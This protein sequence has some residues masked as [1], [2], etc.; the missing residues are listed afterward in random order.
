[1]FPINDL[2]AGPHAILPTG[3]A[4]Q[5]TGEEAHL[6]VLRSMLNGAEERSAWA[7]LHAAQPAKPTAKPFVEV[8]ILDELVGRLTPATSAEFLP[9]I[10]HLGARV[11]VAR[12]AIRGSALKVDVTIRAARAGDLPAAWIEENRD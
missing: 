12:A 5:V 3:R 7:T 9:A 8:R 2:P 10:E 4:V 1:M 6:D 11:A